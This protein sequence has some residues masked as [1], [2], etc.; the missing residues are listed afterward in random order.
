[1]N[2]PT[3]PSSVNG[4]T[5]LIFLHV[6]K[7]AGTTLKTILS[8]Q[9]G[10]DEI[11]K[12]YYDKPD[13]TL[14]GQLEKILSL[15]KSQADRIK[16][17]MGHMGFGLHEHLAW[18]CTYFTVLRD[19]I[20]RAISSYYQTRRAKFDKLRHDAQR[21]NLR[22]FVSSG[23]LKA[24][25]NG[26]TRLLSGAALNE[27]LLGKEV[28][29]GACTEEMLQQA[30]NNL[31]D[32]AAVGI[33]ERFDESLMLLMQVFGWS[34][35]YYVKSNVGRNKT[36]RNELS[37]D[38]LTCLERHNE[39]D[40]QLYEHATHVFNKAVVR[41]GIFFQRRTASFRV[42]NRAYGDARRIMAAVGKLARSV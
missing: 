26:Q 36:A 15:S 38:T 42:V 11:A 33:S 35:P 3:H 29:Y 16:I 1:M 12:C 32:F 7:T 28:E 18:P 40:L 25:D 24:M 8:R 17:V 41:Q 2:A 20:D 23:L 10:P 14:K 34:K 27:D 13:K 30:K 5:R 22:D 4:D 21:L 9:Y 19:P 39:L 6:P 37:R 31:D